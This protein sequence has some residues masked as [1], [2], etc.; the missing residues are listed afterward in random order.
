MKLPGSGEI[1]V[2]VEAYGVCFSDMFAQHGIMGGGFPLC[3][4][5]EIIGKVAAVGK[6][7][8][9]WK[10]GDRVGAGWHGGHDN[11]CTAC[12]KG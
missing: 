1:L 2:K 3:S 4:G 5:H 9:T 10:V 7:V 8:T 6:D 12:K 11:T